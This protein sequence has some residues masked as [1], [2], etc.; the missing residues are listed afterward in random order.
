MGKDTP[1]IYTPLLPLAAVYGMAVRLRNKLFD[2]NILKSRS[3]DVPVICVGNISVGGTGK[4]PHT[5]Y[6]IRLL[7]DEF[8]VCVLS[9]GYKRK[10]K[11][12]VIARKNETTIEDIGDEPFQM[13]QKFPD[14]NVAADSDRCNGI[15]HLIKEAANDRKQQVIVLDDAYQH[16]YVKAGIYILLIDYNRRIRHDA[17]LPAGRLREPE[18]GKTRADIIIVSKCPENIS[19][20]KM[21]EIYSEISPKPWQEV[22][23]THMKYGNMYRIFDKNRNDEMNCK[24]ISSDMNIL[25]LT[26]I[27]SP[28]AITEELGRYTQKITSMVFADHHNFSH[29]DMDNLKHNFMSMP[30]GK[31]IIVTTEKDAARL[32]FHPNLDDKL[33]PYIYALPVE[34]SFLNNETIKFNQK[35]TE[36]VRKNSRNSSIPQSKDANKS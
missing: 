35:I 14:I 1:H 13:W 10:S 32:I 26:G 30:E 18:N 5:E 29:E 33:K 27:A 24:D 7:K 9:R 2:W 36:Y 12:F 21:K 6:L 4:T 3:F 19:K 31:R 22:F 16:R 20:E 28:K 23:F 17:L 8:N 25:L 15:D 11:G 34:V